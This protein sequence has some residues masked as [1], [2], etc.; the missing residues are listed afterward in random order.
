MGAE[1]EQDR[2]SG[3]LGEFD[4]KGV[5]VDNPNR[6]QTPN[7]VRDAEAAILEFPQ[8]LCDVSRGRG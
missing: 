8:T 2:Q 5:A 4:G 7:E 6:A 3:R 1:G